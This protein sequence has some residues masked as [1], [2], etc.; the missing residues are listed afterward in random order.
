[1]FSRGITKFLGTY[2]P[3]SKHSIAAP[4]FWLVTTILT[5][6]FPSISVVCSPRWCTSKRMCTDSTVEF[7]KTPYCFLRESN[8][9][10]SPLL[11]IL[12]RPVVCLLPSSS[13][14]FVVK[15]SHFERL[16][17]EFVKFN[18][19]SSLLLLQARFSSRPI[20]FLSLCSS[21]FHQEIVLPR[22]PCVIKTISSKNFKSLLL[23]VPNWSSIAKEV[24]SHLG[25][26]TL[27]SRIS[28]YF[29]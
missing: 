26:C 11:R 16:R 18:E 24:F 12:H 9:T 6:F 5:P 1:M 17:C 10:D 15:E 29:P 14:Q 2:W 7:V 25:S 4:N 19:S 13:S 22:F 3:C 20:D 21:W 28:F 27:L 8:L 23:R